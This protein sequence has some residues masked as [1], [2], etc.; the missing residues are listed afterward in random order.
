VKIPLKCFTDHGL[1]AAMVNTPFLVYTA[2]AFDVTFSDIRWE[3]SVP[4]AT[5]CSELT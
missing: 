2:G 4:D 3:P 1:N 5:P